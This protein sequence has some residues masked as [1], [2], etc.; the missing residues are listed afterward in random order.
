MVDHVG[1]QT[2]WGASRNEDVE[3]DADQLEFRDDRGD[4][5]ARLH[6]HHHLSTFCF[7]GKSLGTWRYRSI[8]LSCSP[9]ILRTIEGQQNGPFV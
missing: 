7:E 5:L 9:F 3:D 6:S 8:L 1:C 4:S 2:E